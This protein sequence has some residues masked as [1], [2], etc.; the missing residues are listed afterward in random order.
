MERTI[1]ITTT[2][3]RSDW[4]FFIIYALIVVFVSL[5]I[6]INT[7]WI[8]LIVA[9]LFFSLI[10]KLNEKFINNWIRKEMILNARVV[11]NGSK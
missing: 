9:M 3:Y 7:W 2:R 1:E 5:T 11:K 8:L 4:Y 10:S 6:M